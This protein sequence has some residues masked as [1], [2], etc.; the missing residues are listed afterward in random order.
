MGVCLW[1]KGFTME[2]TA[3]ICLQ[4]KP[5]PLKYSQSKK[6]GGWVAKTVSSQWISQ[7]VVTLYPRKGKTFPGQTSKVLVWLREQTAD[8][9]R[10]RKELKRDSRGTERTRSSNMSAG[11]ICQHSSAHTHTVCKERTAKAKI[12]SLWFLSVHYMYLLSHK[13][14]ILPLRFLPSTLQRDMQVGRGGAWGWSGV[15]RVKSKQ[16]HLLPRLSSWLA[17]GPSPAFT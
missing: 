12:A 3:I 13:P 14:H 15:G 17:A 4:V 16:I 5:L 7:G 6:V 10:G 9:T 8:C 11:A 1:Q 2:P